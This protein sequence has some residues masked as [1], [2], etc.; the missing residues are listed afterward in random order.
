MIQNKVDKIFLFIFFT[1]IAGLKFMDILEGDFFILFPI[2]QIGLDKFGNISDPLPRNLTG[3]VVDLPFS[4]VAQYL[5]GVAKLLEFIFGLKIARVL[6][7]VAP[8]C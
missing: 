6:V 8:P 3:L 1:Y 2:V 5:V 4:R 7:G